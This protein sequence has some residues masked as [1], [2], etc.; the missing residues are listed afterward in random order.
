MDRYAGAVHRYLVSALGDR[1]AADELDQEFAVRFLRG[2]FHRA[3]PSRGRF[4]AF[5]KRSLRNLMIDYRRRCMP[6]PRPLGDDLPEPTDT[7]T[8]DADFVRRFTA[9]WRS[10][11]LSRAWAMP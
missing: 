2:D 1:D 10:Q 9:T 7:L 8:G 5:V 11:V 6:R 4:R 3:N